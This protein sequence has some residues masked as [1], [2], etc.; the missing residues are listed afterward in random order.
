[1]KLNHF[2]LSTHSI[3]EFAINSPTTSEFLSPPIHNRR[4]FL[5]LWSP[6][7]ALT[8][9]IIITST[10]SVFITGK[11]LETPPPRAPF[12]YNKPPICLSI[13]SSIRPENKYTQT[14]DLVSIITPVLFCCNA[15]VVSS[16]SFNVENK[17][18][19]LMAKDN[20][21]AIKSLD[22][23]LLVS[24]RN[25]STVCEMRRT[26]FHVPRATSASSS[27]YQLHI[28]LVVIVVHLPRVGGYVSP[29]CDGNYVAHDNRNKPWPYTSHREKDNFT[30]TSTMRWHCCLWLLSRTNPMN[31]TYPGITSC[32][33]CL[34][35]H[36]VCCRNSWCHPETIVVLCRCCFSN[37]NQITLIRTDIYQQI[38]LLRSLGNCA[39][40]CT[41]ELLPQLVVLLA[42]KRSDICHEKWPR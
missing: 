37:Y 1:M 5:W 30:I 42:V 33:L 20:K 16:L 7:H 35:S 17:S 38:I 9:I 22:V 15:L 24:A 31:C 3:K 14:P 26:E 13:S 12:D 11:I 10:V 29:R 4:K 19:I 32:T 25:N 34:N 27:N 21:V 18:K 23:T 6:S 2:I 28:R 40:L 36:Q 41:E 39:L 8:M